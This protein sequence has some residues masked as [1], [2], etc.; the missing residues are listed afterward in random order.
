MSKLII[1]KIT[2][3]FLLST[4][5]RSFLFEQDMA[6]IIAPL[7]TDFESYEV[8]V[9][10]KLLENKDFALAIEMTLSNDTDLDKPQFLY[11][12]EDREE[13]FKIIVKTDR[14][15]DSLKITEL[16]EMPDIQKP[17]TVKNWENRVQAVEG[18]TSVYKCHA[19]EA[20]LGEIHLPGFNTVH[21]SKAYNIQLP[22][23]NPRFIKAELRL[24]SKSLTNLI[25]ELESDEDFLV[26]MKILTE[27]AQ[28]LAAFESVNII[29]GDLRESNVLLFSDDS[30]NL[31]PF[32]DDMSS[33]KF[34]K[35]DESDQ[36]LFQRY[37]NLYQPIEMRKLTKIDK[38][39]LKVIHNNVNED[40]VE[41][42]IEE[43]S[44]SIGQNKITIDPIALSMATEQESDEPSWDYQAYNYSVREDQY[45]FGV[46]LN[47]I[48]DEFDMSEESE[49]KE[50]LKHSLEELVSV[51]VADEPMN[52]PSFVE[53][54]KTLQMISG[55]EEDVYQ[56]FAEAN[57][58]LVAQETKKREVA[59]I[60]LREAIVEHPNDQDFFN[61]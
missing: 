20:I 35:F 10:N 23:D 19:R 21:T 46:I 3:L 42:E 37:R 4:N 58:E 55:F 59:H 14:S 44:G 33:L 40:F 7:Y 38:N 13:Y 1:T 16:T 30:N 22:G 36:E 39:L 49:Y 47:N 53:V 9:N 11:L 18:S 12:D 28:I 57:T 6:T 32:I 51:L 26:L 56:I 61:F 24:T 48:V 43:M 60:T 27:L 41:S 5:T 34:V 31:H 50:Q 54:Y 52:R 15:T 2:L 45:A 25:N 29:T 8:F 17:L